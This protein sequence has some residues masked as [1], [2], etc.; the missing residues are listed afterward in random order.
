M[1]LLHLMFYPLLLLG[2]ATLSPAD[3]RVGRPMPVATVAA[4]PVGLPAAPRWFYRASPAEIAFTGPVGAAPKQDRALVAGLGRGTTI[5]SPPDPNSQ[6][7]LILTGPAVAG[8]NAWMPVS[9]V[10]SGN[11]FALLADRWESWAALDEAPQRGVYILSLG[12]L[13]AGD[14]TLEVH[15]RTMAHDAHPSGL[16]AI[17]LAV[18]G[19]L[20]FSVRDL[21]AIDELQA[22]PSLYE[23]TLKPD[24]CGWPRSL[25]QQPLQIGWTL[26]P[27]PLRADHAASPADA[28]AQPGLAV[29]TVDQLA[30]IKGIETGLP[31]RAD[32]PKV[33]PLI[34]GKQAFARIIGPAV[35][36]DSWMSVREVEWQGAHATIRADVWTDEDPP[37]ARHRTVA[38]CPAAIVPLSIPQGAPAGAPAGAGGP[39]EGHA[40]VDVEWRILTL[41]H[42][43]GAYVPARRVQP[44]SAATSHVELS[45]QPPPAAAR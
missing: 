37:S 13:P 41:D 19:T 11:T 31:V 24:P 9:L 7:V 12:K 18:M 30:V 42:Q 21:A 4:A 23:D 20:K 10:R 38:A 8:R 43:T 17:K 28:V 44:P 33:G 27:R 15:W 25:Y 29:G 32:P 14:Y 2:F 36:A 1:I 5:A 35:D 40:A 26:E 39:T 45:Q 6:T 3:E 34:A 22:A 16:F